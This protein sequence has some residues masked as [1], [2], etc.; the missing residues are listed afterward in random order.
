MSLFRIIRKN[1]PF[2]PHFFFNIENKS[3]THG[4]ID[5]VYNLQEIVFSIQENVISC[6]KIWP[7]LE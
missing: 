3:I 1:V 4:N 5:C 6:R 7:N 2:P